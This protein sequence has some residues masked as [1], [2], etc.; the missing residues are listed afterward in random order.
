[1]MESAIVH[2]AIL[3]D[4]Q[5]VALQFADWRSVTERAGTRAELRVFNRHIADHDDLVAAIGDCEIVVLMRE[6]TRFDAGLL[7]RLPRLRLLVTTGGRN[8]SIDLAAARSHGVRV[9]CTGSV[10]TGTGEHTWALIMALARNIPAEVGAFRAGGPWQVGVGADLSGKRMG[11]IGLGRIGARVARVALAFEMQVQAWSQNLT[12]ARC[13]E[14]GVAHAGSLDALLETSDYV[15]IHL[16]LGD[17]TRG[18][19]NAAALRRMRPT[20]FL[21]NT[22]RGPIIEEAAL[23]AA[24]RERG[25]AGAALDVF[26]T[27]PLPP[28]H[29]YRG[30][31]NLVATSHI[32][33]VTR[34]CYTTYYRDVI[35]DIL[36]WLEGRPVRVLN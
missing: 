32:G 4:Y 2:C 34:D 16:V 26:D 18:L 31:D 30:L 35:E 5:N 28:D 17:R 24:L 1:M 23:V 6:R 9:C 10:T 3:D 29:P 36:G 27:E 19:I 21:V 33:Y 12:Q 14:V 22:S 20:A 15:S 25:I 7:A 11:M 8:P 13:D